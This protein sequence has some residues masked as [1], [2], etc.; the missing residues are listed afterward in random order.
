MLTRD[1]KRHKQGFPLHIIHSTHNIILLRTFK[2]S[3]SNIRGHV[4]GWEYSTTVRG[5][6]VTRARPEPET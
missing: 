1:N 6:R 4:R 2:C 3:V 5:K